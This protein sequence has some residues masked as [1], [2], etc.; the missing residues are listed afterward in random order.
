MNGVPEYTIKLIL[1][2]YSLRDRAIYWLDNYPSKTFNTWAQLSEAF[3]QKYFPLQKT[4]RFRSE[5]NGFAQDELETLSEAWELYNELLRKC[6]HHGMEEWH[7]IQ[8][9]YSHLL[10]KYKDQLM[11][12]SGGAFDELT[13]AQAKELIEKVARSEDSWTHK[14]F[15]GIA[16]RERL[17]IV[18]NGQ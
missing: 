10:K 12:C 9:F 7:L 8:N 16:K 13:E 6:P 15:Q 11:A 14:G 3:L 2:P 1:F 5:I 4:M 18:L 17:G